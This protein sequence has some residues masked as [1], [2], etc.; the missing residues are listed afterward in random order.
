[1][2]TSQKT[3]GILALQGGF[4]KHEDML[5]KC[6]VQTVQVRTAKDLEKCDGI[7]LPGGE[8][9]TMTKLIE[10]NNL[11]DALQHFCQVKPVL[12]T[13]AGAI[14]LSQNAHDARVR[15]LCIM[16]F[17]I[18]R[19]AYGRQVDSFVTDINIK[20]LEKTFE[21]IFIRAPKIKLTENSPLIRGD[22]GGFKEKN[23]HIH[24]LATYNNEPVFVR[25]R[26]TFALTFHPELTDD[27]R[28]HKLFV[29]NF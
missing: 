1:M 18:E 22:M 3:I 21:A 29:E 2:T 5:T 6:G 26:S 15:P 17:E 8:S 27:T 28:I 16:D 12:G 13:C 10:K 11:F 7:I 14:L 9:T 25:Q 19:N 23:S 4:Q 24:I 20:G